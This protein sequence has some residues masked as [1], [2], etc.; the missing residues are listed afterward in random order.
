HYQSLP[1]TLTAVTARATGAGDQTTYDWYLYLLL[2]LWPIAVYLSARLLG[3]ERWPSAAAAAVAPLLVS[4]P[5][6]AYEGGRYTWRGHGAYSQ[7]WAMWTLPLAWGFTW[8][9][10]S[11]GKRYAAAAAA[12]ALTMAFHFITGYLAVLTV[13]VWVLVAPGASFWRRAARG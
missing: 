8:R 10:V 13:G 1:H 12:L 6:D 5:G 11:Q 4:A 9:A 2:A 3:L 7:L